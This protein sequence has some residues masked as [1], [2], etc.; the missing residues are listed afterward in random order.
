MQHHEAQTG[1]TNTPQN[2]INA[3]TC[4]NATA[5]AGTTTTPQTVTN[6][7][8]G[9]T[10]TAQA[11]TTNVHSTVTTTGAAKGSKPSKKKTETP[12]A[13]KATEPV[14]TSL[15]KTVANND[16]QA[17]AT[18]VNKTQ[19]AG[20]SAPVVASNVVN[21]TISN[22]SGTSRGANIVVGEVSLFVPRKFRT[23]GVKRT[24]DEVGNI[25][26]QQSVNKT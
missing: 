7:Q 10:A 1:T 19:A 16:T 8:T 13:K 3:Q 20:P 22:P 18:S 5:Q 15:N 24:I 6:A 14:T 23:T 12:A 17:A 26:T 21:V 9:T 11:G 2:G 25:G 4:T